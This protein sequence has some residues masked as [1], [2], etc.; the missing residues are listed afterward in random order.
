MMVW[1]VWQVFWTTVPFHVAMHARTS[2]CIA[3][4]CRNLP[5]CKQNYSL[6]C[7]F[8]SQTNQYY[9]IGNA[10]KEN[11]GSDVIGGHYNP[12]DAPAPSSPQYMCSP[13][14]ITECEVG[15]LT[16]KHSALSV[17]G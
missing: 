5:N 3:K 17:D 11:C 8:L 14:D 4:W 10:N 12:F 16:G 7:S 13:S 9:R 2:Y 6:F 15:D 1:Q